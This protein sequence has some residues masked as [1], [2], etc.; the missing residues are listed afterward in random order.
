MQCNVSFFFYQHSNLSDLGYEKMCKVLLSLAP[1]S[2]SFLKSSLFKV[3]ALKYCVF[4][5]SMEAYAFVDHG[6]CRLVAPLMSRVTN[7]HR[8]RACDTPN[9]CRCKMN[10]AA[11]P[12]EMDFGTQR[13]RRKHKTVFSAKSFLMTATDG[14]L[15][16]LSV[17]NK[18]NVYQR[19]PTRM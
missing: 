5:A 8:L 11:T 1:Q 12:P 15:P 6:W 16:H 3:T 17:Q 14:P 7:N 10:L 19:G 13:L 9:V 4:C 18:N 2:T